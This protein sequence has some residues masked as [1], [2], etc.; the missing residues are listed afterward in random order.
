MHILVATLIL[1]LLLFGPHLWVQQVL[2][3]HATPRDDFPGTGG[4]FAHHLL[5]RLQLDEVQV[6]TSAVGDH[7]DPAA[8]AV[9]LT[10]DKLNGKSLTADDVVATLNHHR[11]EESTSSMKAFA[12]QISEVRADGP[13]RVIID[14]VEGN[15]DYPFILSTGAFSIVPSEDG[16]ATPTAGVAV[17]VFVA[18][19]MTEMK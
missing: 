4:E 8:R 17:M 15:A 10:P 5:K 2:R 16:K 6:E 18:V 19:S 9:R 13:N 1:L 14:L 12:N 3:R 7:Y 11:G